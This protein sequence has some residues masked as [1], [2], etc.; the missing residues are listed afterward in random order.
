M[1]LDI[2]A[3]YFALWGWAR[4]V[5]SKEL[6]ANIVMLQHQTFDVVPLTF[7][8]ERYSALAG[9]VVEAARQTLAGRTT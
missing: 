6:E 5:T 7:G 1:K 9:D 3:P 8:G 2:P 4:S